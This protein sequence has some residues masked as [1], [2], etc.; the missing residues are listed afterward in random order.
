MK[1]RKRPASRR[2]ST[3][4]VPPTKNPALKTLEMMIQRAF[5]G[6][7]FPSGKYS[8]VAARR[9]SSRITLLVRVLR[10]RARRVAQGG[11]V[12]MSDRVCFSVH[13]SSSHRLTWLSRRWHPYA[14]SSAHLGLQLPHSWARGRPAWENMLRRSST[15]VPPPRAE[16][17]TENR[18][19]TYEG[20]VEGG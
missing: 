6:G 20:K 11:K 4:L 8:R 19:D 5:P 7:A 14:P 13:A 2:T 12:L 17:R 10:P 15:P 9:E 3:S 1:K 18:G 16:S